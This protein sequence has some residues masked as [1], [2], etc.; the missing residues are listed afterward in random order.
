MPPEFK[1]LLDQALGAAGHG[2][3]LMR[4]L[5]DHDMAEV[6]R[7]ARVHLY[8]GAEREVYASTLAES[9]ATG[10]PAVTRRLGA[11][12]ER[13]VDGRSGFLTP[14]DEAFVNCAVLCLK[15]D[16]VYRGRSRDAVQMQR[17]RS[18]DD[19]AAEVEAMVV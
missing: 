16:I 8:P 1:P 10:L 6:Y 4:P 15:E 19:A 5:A 11:A 17:G 12:E 7:H 18:W 9:Q 13:I 14:D 3:R 2:V